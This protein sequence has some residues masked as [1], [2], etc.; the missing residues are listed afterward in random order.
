MEDYSKRELLEEHAEHHI[1]L[2]LQLASLREKSQE[3]DT[4][5]LRLSKALHAKKRYVALKEDCSPEVFLDRAF[6]AAEALKI[7][8]RELSPNQELLSATF[9]Q[10]GKT[11]KA[12]SIPK[13][14]VPCSERISPALSWHDMNFPSPGHMET[15]MIGCVN[16][17]K[18]N[19]SKTKN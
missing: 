3:D 12:Y 10:K 4:Q 1:E 15:F 19:I 17:P 9:A 6:E 11:L 14:K 8:A 18:V 5:K 7:L 2:L 16:E 13:T